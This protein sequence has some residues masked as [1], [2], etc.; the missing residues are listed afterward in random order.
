MTIVFTTASDPVQM[1]LVASLSR[2]GFREAETTGI[3]WEVD[4]DAPKEK[5]AA[6]QPMRC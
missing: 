6:R 3:P 2:P 5:P 4:E 1:G